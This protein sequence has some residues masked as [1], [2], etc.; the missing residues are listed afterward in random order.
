MDNN[1]QRKTLGAFW[2]QGSSKN[3]HYKFSWSWPDV[4]ILTKSG[5][6][7]LTT[8]WIGQIL[9]NQNGGD[10]SRFTRWK[11]IITPKVSS[12]VTWFIRTTQHIKG[13]LK[14]RPA[15]TIFVSKVAM[16]KTKPN[17]IVT[18]NV[19]D[20]GKF[21]HWDSRRFKTVL[22]IQFFRQ[23]LTESE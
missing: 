4:C 6:T 12:N 1:S 15:G 13:S 19:F 5:F 11:Y 23:S 16:I 7:T 21:S 22:R 18:Y 14:S 20:R 8:D 3:S 10:A 17:S 9:T 2:W